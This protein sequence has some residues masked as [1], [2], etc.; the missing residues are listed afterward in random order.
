MQEAGTCTRRQFARGSSPSSLESSYTLQDNWVW[1][2]LDPRTL[3][4]KKQKKNVI[5]RMG[6][7]YFIALAAVTKLY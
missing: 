4:L 3:F 1:H 6:P 5:N 2:T 7:V